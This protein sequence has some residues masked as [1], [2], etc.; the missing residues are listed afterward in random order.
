MCSQ[1][2]IRL[3]HLGMRVR[4][5]RGPQTG[6]RPGRAPWRPQLILAVL[7]APLLVLACGGLS[8]PVAPGDDTG[9]APPQHQSE[10]VVTVD[11]AGGAAAARLVADPAVIAPTGSVVLRVENRGDLRLLYGRPIVVERWDGSEWIETEE[12]RNAAWTMELII[13]QPHQSGVQQRWPFREGSVPRPGW[14]RFTKRV[15]TDSGDPNFVVRARV[16]VTE[17]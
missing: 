6:H 7:A 17:S 11:T 2:L 16:R 8:S 10:G 4:L 3:P 15:Q 1:S 14:Y 13:L 12:S 9:G 5:T